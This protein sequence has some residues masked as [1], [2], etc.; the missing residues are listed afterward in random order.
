MKESSILFGDTRSLV[1][2]ITEPDEGAPSAQLGCLL[3][4]AGAIHRV[5]PQRLYVRLARRLAEL[6]V[7][8]LR[9]D[10]SGIGDSRLRPDH[11]PF[12]DAALA[13]ARNAM[14]VL[15]ATRG[16]RRFLAVGVCWGADNAL[17]LCR[18]DTRLVGGGL[19]DFYFVLSLHHWMRLYG[20]RVL[21]ARSW[22]HL[23]RGRSP[24]FRMGVAAAAESLRLRRSRGRTRPTEDGVMPVKPP[25]E[26]LADLRALANRGV[27]LC[28]VF[29]RGSASWD[30]YHHRFRPALEAHARAG[31][32]QLRFLSGA[33]HL[34][35]LQHCQRELLNGMVDWV[36]GLGRAPLAAARQA[37]PRAVEVRVR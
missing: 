29:T 30:H 32:A 21:S 20:G 5:G 19:I 15:E 7:T 18:A 37:A 8:S 3:L 9:F 28:F 26:V 24:A 13:E 11:L 2:V 36:R 10:Y 27:E 34:F 16:I 12:A 4:N 14:D 1:G 25:T 22:I 35:T 33:D 6:G 23:L 17:R 31:R